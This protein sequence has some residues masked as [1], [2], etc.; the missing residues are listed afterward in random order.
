[1]GIELRVLMV[2]ERSRE[3]GINDNASCIMG[4]MGLIYLDGVIGWVNMVGVT[5]MECVWRSVSF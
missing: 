2:E 3:A 1:M 5:W 4:H